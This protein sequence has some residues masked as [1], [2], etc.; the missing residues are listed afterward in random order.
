MHNA[1]LASLGL[2][3]WRYLRLPLP[4]ELFAETVAALPALGF[5]GVN[6]TIPHKEAALALATEATEVARAIGAAN[7]LTFDALTGAVHADNTDARGLLEA[8]PASH[9]PEGRTALVLG[10]G[11]AARAAVH[12][13]LSA[14]A[15]DVAVLNRTRA[16]AERLVADLGGGRVVDDP[17]AADLIVNATSVGLREFKALPVPA[18]TVGAGSCVVDMVYRDG[19]TR[20]LDEARRRGAV[21][22]DGLEILVAQGA[23][24][25]ERWTGRPA[26]RDAMRRAA[27]AAPSS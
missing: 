20:L 18:D 4:P 26:P 2:S 12:T 5:V 7:T 3:D 23:A 16:R 21:G 22:V 15:A 8:I 9:A 11:G 6:A 10:A 1:A 19:G 13:L 24:S 25:F 14:G 27:T 17:F